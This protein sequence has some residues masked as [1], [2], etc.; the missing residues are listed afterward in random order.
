MGS[1]L[2]C[3]AKLVSFYITE[4]GTERSFKTI[5]N[6]RICYG[7]FGLYR[8][9]NVMFLFFGFFGLN[10][11]RT[12]KTELIGR[13]G[14]GREKVEGKWKGKGRESEGKGKSKGSA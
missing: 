10:Q 9:W 4:T 12:K 14:E 7:S 1:Q 3:P 2:E 11:K 13:V 8:N 6:K 5:L